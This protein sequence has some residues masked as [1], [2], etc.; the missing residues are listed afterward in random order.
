MP[1]S[2]AHFGDVCAPGVV[3]EALENALQGVEAV[4]LVPFIVRRRDD[5]V[6]HEAHH[7]IAFNALNGKTPYGGAQ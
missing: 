5:I 1:G 4:R 6:V 7:V 2:A 3:N